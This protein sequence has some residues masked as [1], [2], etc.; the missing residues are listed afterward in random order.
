MKKYRLAIIVLILFVFMVSSC[1]NPAVTDN[2]TN[3]PLNTPQNTE[4]STPAGTLPAEAVTEAININEI[5]MGNEN[6]HINQIGYLP[7]DE[8]VVIVNGIEGSFLVFNTDSGEQVFEG[9][10]TGGKKDVASG[11]TVYYGDFSSINEPGSYCVVL[12]GGEAS[13]PFTVKENVYKDIKNAMIKAFYY[14]RCGMALEE[15]F[16]G[17]WK[18]AVCHL[19][20]GYLYSDPNVKID[21]TGGWHDAGDYGKYVSAGATAAAH[22]LL[23]Y[24]LMP[25][26]FE[27]SLNLP[28]SGN[29]VPDI[30]NEVRYELDWLLKM[31]DKSS[32][33]V[34]HKIATPN[35][36]GFVLPERDTQTECIYDI[37][38]SAT[39]DFAAITAMASRIYKPFDSEFSEK[40][41]TASESAWNWLEQNPDAP[42]FKNPQG[43]NSGEYGDSQSGDERLWASA[44]LYRTTGKEIYHEYFKSAY[45]K[46]YAN[47]FGFGWNDMSGFAAAAYLFNETGNRDEEILS[48]LKSSFMKKA[49]GYL[50][51]SSQYDGYKTSMASTDYYWGS[52]M[53]AM[54]KS[55]H[56]IVAYMLNPD[57]AYKQAAQDN[58][59]YLLGRNALDQCFVTG[60]GSKTVLNPHHRPSGGDNVTDPVPGFVA[61]G[62]NSGLQDPD[63]QN[64]L[65]AD[66][67]PARAYVDVQGSYSTNEIDIYWNSPAVFVAA[68]FDR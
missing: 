14:Q 51:V 66:G 16:A 63:A 37:S 19:G 20:E 4:I 41:M 52:N 58:F 6:V 40:A 57:A 62:P 59:H 42:G 27:E 36:P 9:Q 22:M 45:T 38:P 15:T 44:E 64:L 5:T 47:G 23:A 43:A 24:D 32:G 49:D 17:V 21:A 13:Y 31:Q 61:G 8:K 67:P 39:G 55:I 54:N 7:D 12:P 33:G 10:L 48:S 25:E 60:F 28:E 2:S 65:K 26:V 11:D 50:K 3:T 68:F 35:W 18:H 29:G 46:N 56:M 1:S 30:L 53:G 34:Y